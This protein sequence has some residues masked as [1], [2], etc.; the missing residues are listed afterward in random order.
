MIR[1]RTSRRFRGKGL[2]RRS[3]GFRANYR[4]PCIEWLEARQLLSI[5]LGSIADQAAPA[6]SILNVALNGQ[7]TDHNQVDYFISIEQEQLTNSTVPS[8][9]VTATLPSGNQSLDIRVDDE[10]DDI[11]G[12]MFFQ[13]FNDLTPN[14]VNQITQLVTTK[15]FYDGLTFHRVI[16]NFMIQGGDPNGNGTGGPGFNFDDEFNADLRFNSPGLLAMANGGADTNG[17]QFFITAGP[18]REL[19]FKHAIFGFLTQGDDIRQKIADVPVEANNANPPETSKPVNTVTITS[20]T[21]FNDTQNGLL[22]LSV[23]AGTTGSA[24]IKVMAK[25]DVTQETTSQTFTVTF[26]ADPFGDRPFL[27]S[28]GKTA[29]IDPIETS[30]DKPVSFN[31][32]AVD[33]N[34]NSIVYYGQALEFGDPPA[35]PKFT[36]DVDSNTGHGTITP[37]SGLAPGVYGVALLVRAPGVD[38]T[39]LANWDVQRVPVYM[40]PLAPTSIELVAASDTG[41]SNSD[42]LT[43]L[44]NT[45]GK[46][47]Q[48]KVNGV[49]S[50]ADVE[51]FDGDVSIGHGS[52]NGSDNFVIITTSG[53]H[54][55][56]EGTRSITAKQTLQNQKVQ[57]WNTDTTTNLASGLS[58]E[59][60]IN[61]DATP[62]QFNFTPRISAPPGVLYTCP[63][64]ATDPSTPVTYALSSAPNGMSINSSTGLITWTPPAGQ[65]VVASVTVVATDAAG[66]TNQQ[67]YTINKNAPALTPASPALGTMTEDDA[68]KTVALSTFINSGAG[69]T[70]IT[71]SNQGAVVG[72]IAL[73]SATGKG[74]WEYSLD[75]NNFLA[76]GT[77]G[78]TSS[79]LLPKTAQLR[80]TPDAQNGET[81]S[82][83]Y[84]AWDSVTGQSGTKVSTSANGN[85]T[86]FSS[87]SDTA[88][89]T[90]TA[91]NDA[92]VL[93][94]A[95]HSMGSTTSATAIT[96]NLS[97]TFI[98]HGA[99]TTTITDVDQNALVG[100]IALTG[101]TG[102]GTWEYS[103]DNGASFQSLGA[104]AIGPA[105]ALLLSSSAQLRY[106]PD[107]G[108][109]SEMASI[110]YRAWDQ[111]GG[112]AGQ[113]VNF[114]QVA[115]GGTTAFSTAT[116]A[117]TLTVNDAPVLAAAS[118][119]P[120]LGTTDEETAKTI[121]LVG[122]FINNGTGST[123]MTDPNQNDVTGGIALIAVTGKG[124][125]QYSTDGVNF[126]NIAPVSDAS[127]LLL[128]GDAQLRYQPDHNNGEAATIK[129]RAWDQT[130]GSSGGR[131]NLS[132][133]A[134][135]GVSTPFS[136]AMD[137]ASLSVTDVNDAP[138]LTSAQPSL[139]ITVPNIAKTVSLATF[140][141]NGTGTTKITDV[142]NGAE[143]GGIAL[144]GVSGNGVG[145][146]GKGWQYS[147][148]G[149]TFQPVGTVSATSALLLPKTAQLRYTPDGK[150]GETAT[151][152][153]RAWDATD[154]TKVD[155]TANGG[156]TAFSTATDTA[157]LTVGVGSLSGFVYID[158]NNDGQRM[159][160]GGQSHLALPGAILRLLTQ[161]NQG[162]WVEMA[163]K[164]PLMTGAD[165]SYRFGGLPAGTFR[166]QEVQPIDYQDGKD[167]LGTIG[168][169]AKGTVGQDL[170]EIQLGPGENGVN[171]NFAELGFRPELISR[172]LFLA[173]TLPAAQLIVQTNDVPIVDLAK[174]AAGNGYSTTYQAGGSSVA[175]AAPDATITDVD[176][177]M[178]ASLTA[179]ITSA[180]DGNSEKLEA[181]TSNTPLAANY[182]NGVLT[183]SGVAEL[184]VYQQVLRTIK[185]SD[186]A[187]SPHTGTRQITIVANDGIGLSQPATATV[188]IVSA[189]SAQAA[190]AT[191]QAAQ[192]ASTQA[193]P[194]ATTS[195][196][197]SLQSLTGSTASSKNQLSSTASSRGRI[198][199]LAALD[200]VLAQ[201]DWL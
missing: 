95:N 170:F 42:K 195:S 163:G 43:N 167:T 164:S 63:V 60:T 128:D 20:V 124:T 103:I 35:E 53:P 32:S 183:L 109:S 24:V 188:T 62:P 141:N 1:K 201:D 40:D 27:G 12:D 101:M 123:T 121:S 145:I 158:V 81:A 13:L 76:V 56:A 91:L 87:G 177:P 33:V 155:T 172:R 178:L 105:H 166:I 44:N 198:I 200:A 162:N 74:K 115:V 90:V 21:V 108:H 83:A 174:S 37:Q 149:T 14:T 140:I 100:G 137:T 78:S 190:P 169:L 23:P 112:S 182:T 19:D 146:S 59:L 5:F 68:A 199:S 116:D 65:A 175:V 102:K 189:A 104:L 117:A 133:A 139:G 138:V 114:Q 69:T 97:G 99:G 34:G 154:A 159:T 6:G 82:V 131:V 192:A 45:T 30:V 26:Q 129:Y 67:T 107:V 88:S 152:T 49:V 110:Q 2:G 120:S 184:A 29:P 168:G 46:T 122:T 25:D 16:Q 196:A 165:G 98:N 22:R 156:A 136:I 3:T 94:P 7:S 70:T 127:A 85:A 147:L 9:H 130:S 18:V 66:N 144:I 80:Y 194:A 150:N 58:S 185:C 55:L 132:T 50:G 8:P 79:L 86:P 157:S 51:L 38:G 142:D 57:I 153:Y 89:L 52:P 77:V 118:T 193:A 36:V 84:R 75:G 135:V 171:Y 191:S 161:D 113:T 160:S 72:G 11:H 179:T 71:D 54:T 134:A 64:T 96:I 143:L 125:W 41:S 187:A 151:I 148:D 173:S 39:Q 61:V 47:L 17:S 4:H 197:A 186:T 73:F 28:D 15:N 48:F 181:N 106:T 93:T 180:P 31:I 111:T 10:G 176:S 119:S 92:P 126:K